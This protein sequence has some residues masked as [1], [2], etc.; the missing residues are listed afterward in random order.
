MICEEIVS[1]WTVEK[2]NASPKVWMWVPRRGAR[3]EDEERA[4][5]VEAER[6]PERDQE[7]GE[8]AAVPLLPGHRRASS[9]RITPES[10]AR[11]TD[12]SWRCGRGR[13][14]RP[15]VHARAD[16]A[17][18]RVVGERAGRSRPSPPVAPRPRAGSLAGCA[19]SATASRCRRSAHDRRARR[20]PA[21]GRDGGVPRLGAGAREVAVR[22]GGETH[23]L[24]REGG[25][26][27]G[28]APRGAGRRLHRSSSTAPRSGPTRARASSPRG[29][30]GRRASSRSRPPRGAGSR[31][32]SSSIY[33]LHVGT[34]S[35][36]G[37][38]DGVIP[39]LA[40]LRELGVTA[41][42][43]MPVA[44]FPGEPRLGLRRRLPAT[45]RI[46]RTAGRR[47]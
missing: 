39:H 27:R 10:L 47:A 21:S 46:R 40:A 41:I 18:P 16:E 34:F 5:D 37:T 23:D 28:D 36:E 22:I 33:E 30:A 26:L 45:R 2:K 7:A 11:P 12:R 6:E 8:E 17:V 14:A 29:S 35:E 43:L 32:T 4:D 38:F 3:S 20:D 24:A 9:S 19:C 15:A 1:S 31:S 42:E 13:C 25:G 44:T